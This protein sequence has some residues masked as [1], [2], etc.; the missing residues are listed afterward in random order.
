MDFNGDLVGDF[1][2]I[3]PL[4]M[5]NIATERSTVFDGKIHYFDGHFQ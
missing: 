2:V 4:V 5:T 3:Y 1:M